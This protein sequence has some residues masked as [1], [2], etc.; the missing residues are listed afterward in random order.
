MNN[1]RI[2]IDYSRLI[3]CVAKIN[4]IEKLPKIEYVFP[5]NIDD[6]IVEQLLEFCCPF[7]VKNSEYFDEN[8]TQTY[9][10]ILTNIDSN[11]LFG[12]CLYSHQLRCIFCII[13]SNPFY[14]IYNEILK[15]LSSY[16]NSHTE[17]EI[18]QWLN[19]L[20]SISIP[21]NEPNFNIPSMVPNKINLIK[22]SSKNPILSIPED[23]NLTRFVS[24]IKKKSIIHIFIGML[25]ERRVIFVSK[26][27]STL[28]SSVL[29][30][31][32]LIYPLNW[33]HILIP[34]MPSHLLEYTNAPM[35]FICGIHRSLFEKLDSNTISSCIVCN[36]DTDKLSYP[37]E[38]LNDTASFPSSMYTK[39]YRSLSKTKSKPQS[40]SMGFFKTVCKL[41]GKYRNFIITT[42]Q[43]ASF[44]YIR[45]GTFE[46]AFRKEFSRTQSFEQFINERIEM[47][48]DNPEYIDEF[49]DFLKTKIK[50]NHLKILDIHLQSTND[51][52][53][54]SS[55]INECSTSQTESID[56]YA[57]KIERPHS[58][59]TIIPSRPPRPTPDK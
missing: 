58:L 16:S 51:S 25:L 43:I 6:V 31:T 2:R 29:A 23:I 46:I 37:V 17:E 7:D 12:Y 20:D 30:S 22:C 11:F 4:F 13:S 5:D 49:L 50:S 40:C 21:E 47:F 41:I 42:N 48:K 57:V 24:A 54:Y 35:P 28:S 33:Q 1:S 18:E 19:T 26:K 55:R 14:S 9:T 3:T 45:F 59:A 56:F 10:F 38:F 36:L 34:L 52:L 39:L 44:D 8:V 53:M 32:S 27:L 15:L